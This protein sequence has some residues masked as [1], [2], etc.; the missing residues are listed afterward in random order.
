MGIRI[1]GN[2]MSDDL[3]A[4]MLEHATQHDAL[5]FGSPVEKQYADD[6][7]AAA[8]ALASQAARIAELERENDRLREERDANYTH[9]ANMER[10][11]ARA[12][13]DKGDA[14]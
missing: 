10:K 8:D 2:D 7:R 14:T 9:A 3:I 4:R 13:A 11:W 12:V 1:E 6:L 5:A